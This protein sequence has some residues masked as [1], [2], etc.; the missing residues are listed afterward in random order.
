MTRESVLASG[1]RKRQV[2]NSPMPAEHRGEQHA[3]E[4]QHRKCW[5]AR[6]EARRT[7][8]VKKRADRPKR[9]IDGEELVTSRRLYTGLSTGKVDVERQAK[10]FPNKTRNADGQY[11][12]QDP[13]KRQGACVYFDF[14]GSSF[15][16]C[17]L[18][19]RCFKDTDLMIRR[20]RPSR[21]SGVLA[22]LSAA[23]MSALTSGRS[24]A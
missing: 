18:R 2:S 19:G 9:L 20:L 6:S 15:V 7:I 22:L 12:S 4:R 13:T 16:G 14:L 24:S 23:A 11:R 3:C 5:P 10:H 1:R 21:G 17:A 8:M